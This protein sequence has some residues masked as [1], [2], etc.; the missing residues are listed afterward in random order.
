MKEDLLWWQYN[1]IIGKNPI[2]LNKFQVELLS[3][4]SLIGWGAYCEGKSAHGLWSK[5][6]RKLSYYKL[7]GALSSFLC[8]K[9][10]CVSLH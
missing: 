2:R 5:L 4:A 3:D 9:V 6:E 10:F 1:F 8:L 7:F